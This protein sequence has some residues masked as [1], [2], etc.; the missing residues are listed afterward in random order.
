MKPLHFGLLVVGAAL[1]GGLAL[2]LTQ[3]PPLPVVAPTTPAP[4]V[5]TVSPAIVIARKPSPIPTIPP[6]APLRTAAP[7]PV[8]DEP[9]QPAIRKSKPILLA[10]AKPVQPVKP[11]Q[12]TPGRYEVPA[13]SGAA[14][15]VVAKPAPAAP[16]LLKAEAAQ[17]DLPKPQPAK[18]EANVPRHVTLQPGMTIPVRIDQSLTADSFQASLA[19]PLAVDGLVI[20]EKGA[21]VNVRQGLASL[22]TSDGQRVAI[23]TNPW[24][25]PA[26]PSAGMVVRFRVASRVTITERH[27]P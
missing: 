25:K 20:A 23:S 1:V 3:A 17:P 2:K 19:E 27:T 9:P 5:P 13:Q 16:D 14:K 18:P 6:P 15:T 7:E 11:T 4:A 8:F 10:Q 22:V 21:R 26:Q 24:T 12:W